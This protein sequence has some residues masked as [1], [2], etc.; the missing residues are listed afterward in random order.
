MNIIKAKYEIL[1]QNY[2]DD[3]LV[4]MFKH[5]EMCGRTCYKS[6]DKITDNS[7]EKFINMLTSSNHGAMLEH[8]TVYLTIP[9]GTP[10]DDVQYITITY[11][12]VSDN[13]NEYIIDVSRTMSHID[14]KDVLSKIGLSQG[15]KAYEYN[16]LTYRLLHYQVYK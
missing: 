8:G 2:N 14:G 11:V 4:N 9:V 1:E 16:P 15:L 5:I 12:D 10:V 7:Y 3:L 13:N 6:E